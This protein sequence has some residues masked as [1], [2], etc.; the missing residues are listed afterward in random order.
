MRPS[1]NSRRLPAIAG[2]RPNREFLRVAFSRLPLL[3]AFLL[4]CSALQAQVPKAIIT[5][6]RESRPGALV[7]LDAS[8]SVGTGRLW[9]LAVSPE[10]TSFLPVESGLKCIFASP[11]P[12]RYVFVLVVSGTNVNGGAAADMATHS[13][14]L[15]GATPPN[16][17]DVPDPPTPP[18]PASGRRLIVVLRESGSTDTSTATA[19]LKLRT[20]DAI[21]E[22]LR[23]KDHPPP[24]VL[25][26]DSDSPLVQRLKQESGSDRLPVLF[27]LD[28][29]NGEAGKTL[30]KIPMPASAEGVIS[31]LGKAGG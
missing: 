29:S 5:G 19:I 3:A 17:P 2:D 20:D 24:L 22:R 28:F 23:S 1:T 14:T 30:A 13:V 6:P 4:I 25:D 9:L 8:E 26:P 21:L 7:V 12:G 15:A 11:T 31:A 27:V 10:E 18:A 16:P